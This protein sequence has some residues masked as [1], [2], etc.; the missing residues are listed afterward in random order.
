VTDNVST[1]TIYVAGH[2]GMVGSAIVRHLESV[3]DGNKVS[4]ITRDRNQLDLENQSA[5]LDFF[6]TRQIDEVYL[7]AARVGGIHAN[8]EYPADFIYS[9]LV[10]E[11]NIINAAFRGGVQKLLFLGSSCIYPRDCPQPM[12]ESA[13]L[14]GPLESTNEPYAVS[15]IAGIKLCESYNRQ[16]GTDY[17]SVMPTNL[18]GENDNFH[19]QNS[20]V[21]P[22]LMRRIH[23]AKINR[24][25]SVIIWGTGKVMREFLHVDDMASAS[26]FVMNLPGEYYA[27]K[28]DPMLSH[29]NIGT[30]QDVT[31]T[32]LATTLASVIGY[33]GELKFDSSKPEGTPRKLLDVTKLSGLGWD[34]KISLKD[35]LARTYNWYQNNIDIA[36]ES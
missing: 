16:H 3:V 31:I 2:N 36:R 33:Q 12:Q 6:Q 7:C 14:T 35:G 11:S 8:N 32:E 28:T 10:I 1:K 18:Y 20:H 23:E 27:E 26:I 13:L 17:R 4:L 19:P 9:N 29:I 30:G 22:A 15:K 25:E 5:V 34:Y 21:I 24:D